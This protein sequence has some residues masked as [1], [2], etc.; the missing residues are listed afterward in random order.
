MTHK[1]ASEEDWWNEFVREFGA[2][3]LR[4]LAR[5]FDTNPRRLRR[6]A[7]RAGLTAEPAVIRENAKLL[8]TVPD[9]S[10][11]DKLEVT[12]EAIAGARNRRQIPAFSKFGPKAAPPPVRTPVAPNT[13][14]EVVSRPPPARV[15]RTSTLPTGRGLKRRLGKLEP[16][17]PQVV[18]RSSVRRRV[19]SAERMDEVRD[20]PDERKPP[21][22]APARRRP[23]APK[24][25]PV[26]VVFDKTRVAPT[27]PEPIAPEPAAPEPAALEPVAP[28]PVAPKPEVQATP[29][30][31][32]STSA[33][34]SYWTA[35]LSDG[36]Q[37]VI[38]APS[39]P[40]AAALA[41]ARGV[42]VSLEPSDVL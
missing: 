37:V 21:T 9:A 4:E 40:Q 31:A 35:H 34:A 16:A 22:P 7:Q 33:P 1:S 19:V 13:A 12:A 5:R 38:A 36:S 25:A 14:P 8:G 39:L 15:D 3:P 42:V 30:V 32:L 29:A 17:M 10:L 26:K 27:S 18:R 2:T 11:A 24:P 23:R 6:A 20:T 28:K 41:Q